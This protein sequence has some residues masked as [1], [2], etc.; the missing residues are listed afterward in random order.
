LMRLAVERA[1]TGRPGIE[2]GVCGSHCLDP[3]AMS[4]LD[5]Y[6]VDFVACHLSQLLSARLMAGQQ[7]V[8]R[9][10]DQRPGGLG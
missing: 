7:A 10:V 6:R 3:T 2:I 1:R 5:E 4:L 9:Q 8:R